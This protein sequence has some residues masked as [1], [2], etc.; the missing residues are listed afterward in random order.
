MKLLE[1][2]KAAVE[3][4]MKFDPRNDGAAEDDLA[5]VKKDYEKLDTEKRLY[6]DK[7]LLWNPYP[8]SRIVVEPENDKDIR[9]VVVG[10]EGSINSVIYAKD[11]GLDLI[12]SHHPEGKALACMHRVLEMQIGLFEKFGVDTGAVSG[13]A[14]EYSIKR[15]YQKAIRASREDNQGDITETITD[16]ARQY[17]IPW[18]ALHTVA[19]NCVAYYLQG[20]MDREKPNNMDDIL[21]LLMGIPEYQTG[22]MELIGPRIVSG[23]RTGKSGRIMVDMTG[24]EESPKLVFPALSKCVNTIICMHTSEE[25]YTEAEKH[26]VQILCAGHSPSDSLGMNL[27]FDEILPED[28]EITEVAGFR[29]VKRDKNFLSSIYTKT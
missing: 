22:A 14:S 29:R 12:V 25:W 9:K 15:I 2:Y 18:I 1:L 5:V 27:L 28:V 8:D 21:D 7:D 3:V 24:G 6:F 26:G 13:L 23:I 11:N 19:D 10:L 4:G 16:F 20:L 17:K